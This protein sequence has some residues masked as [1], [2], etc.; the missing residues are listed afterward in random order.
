M[1][2][3]RSI[4]RA[5]VTQ[6]FQ[7]VAFVYMPEHVHLVVVPDGAVKIAR[8]L[9]AIKRP[10]SYRIK[11]L[12]KESQDPLLKKLMVQERPGKRVFRFWQAGPGYDR[13]IIFDQELHD[14]LRYIHN[15]PVR[16]GLCGRPGEW[17]WSSW[18][19]YQ[20]MDAVIDPDLPRLH[21]MPGRWG[22]SL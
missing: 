9:W 2:I 16:R 12:L 4:D 1:L 15:N 13:N 19:H 11:V 21:G 6:H 18:K 8:L 7:L 3:S 14:V 17:K 10:F 5:T 22:F 20:D